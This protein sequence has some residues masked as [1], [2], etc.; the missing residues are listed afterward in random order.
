[1]AEQTT[2][3]II[4]DPQLVMI[5][6]HQDFDCPHI[7]PVSESVAKEANERQTIRWYPLEPD[8]IARV[9]PRWTKLKLFF[10]F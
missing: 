9:N 4:D 2:M 1:M 7:L 6:S 10:L 8:E 3:R 5:R